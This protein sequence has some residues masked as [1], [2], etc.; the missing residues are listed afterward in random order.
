[1]YLVFGADWAHTG[2]LIGLKRWSNKIILLERAKSAALNPKYVSQEIVGT[3]SEGYFSIKILFLP[4]DHL[5][6]NPIEMVWIQKK[7]NVE[8]FNFTLKLSAWEHFD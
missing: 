6:L 7:R 2:H 4:V 3:F 5:E 8:N 1:M